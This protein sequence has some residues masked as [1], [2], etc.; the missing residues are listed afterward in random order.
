MYI[1]AGKA[2]YRVSAADSINSAL[3]VN[4]N[5]R[6]ME[7]TDRV[8]LLCLTATD[9]LHEHHYIRLVQLPVRVSSNC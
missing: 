4:L 6:M 3:K 9:I 7:K 8:D 2:A 5:A 1:N